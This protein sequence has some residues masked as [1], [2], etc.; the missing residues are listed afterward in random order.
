MNP[1]F[2]LLVKVNL[3]LFNL[4]GVSGKY[5]LYNQNMLKLFIVDNQTKDKNTK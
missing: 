4:P 2:V 5:K 1:L 3:N